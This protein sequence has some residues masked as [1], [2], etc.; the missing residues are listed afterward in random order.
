MDALADPLIHLVRNAVDHGIESPEVRRELGK[1]PVG[2]LLLSASQRGDSV[3]LRVEDD[4]KGLDPDAIRASAVRKGVLDERAAAALTPAQACEL[5]LRPG[6]STREAVSSVSGRGV[7]MDV[8]A[9]A[10]R[11]LG[12]RLSLSGQVGRGAVVELVLPLTLAILPTL[13][14]RCGPRSLALPLRQVMDLQ[15]FDPGALQWRAGQP[16]LPLQGRSVPVTFLD[17]WLDLPA[18]ARSLLVR[19]TTHHGERGLVVDGVEGREDVVLKPPGRLLRGIPGYGGAA[20]TGDGRIAL[21]LDPD[22]LTAAQ[23]ET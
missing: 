17:Q 8:V 20:V 23:P 6:F 19:V 10:V 14:T 22:G 21:I 5:V 3:M 1:N 13:R 15:P 16:V 18:G 7:G 11:A 9:S 12:G 2:R 4:G